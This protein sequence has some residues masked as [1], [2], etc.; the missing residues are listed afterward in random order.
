MNVC[1]LPWTQ[2]TFQWVCCYHVNP[3]IG[4]RSKY[5]CITR[6]LKLPGWEKRE[7]GRRRNTLRFK[8]RWERKKMQDKRGRVRVMLLKV[9][10]I[11]FHHLLSLSLVLVFFLILFHFLSD[12]YYDDVDHDNVITLAIPQLSMVQ[13]VFSLFST[14]SIFLFFALLFSP[15]EDADDNNFFLLFFCIVFTWQL[16]FSSFFFFLSSSYFSG[17]LSWSPFDNFFAFSWTRFTW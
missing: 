3:E 5:F 11:Q 8:V 17:V 2:F 12:Y 7:W 4:H 1:C 16:Y 15:M 10:T 9:K 6:S 14:F 13:W